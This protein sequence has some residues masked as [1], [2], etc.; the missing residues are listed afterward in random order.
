MDGEPDFE[1]GPPEDGFEYLR[2]VRYVF[3]LS[4]LHLS[5]Y[6]HFLNLFLFIRWEA[7]RVPNVK[8]AKIDESKYIPKEQSVYMPQIPEIPKCPEHLLPLKEWEDSLL[9]D[10]SHLRLVLPL[11]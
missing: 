8:V 4:L 2:R 9:S 7:K 1:S 10:F 11:N 6:L 3:C 5:V